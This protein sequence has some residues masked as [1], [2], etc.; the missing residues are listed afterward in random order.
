MN[1]SLKPLNTLIHTK[2]SKVNTVSHS[3]SHPWA[4]ERLTVCSQAWTAPLVLSPWVFRSQSTQPETTAVRPPSDG[5][6]T[7]LCP[8]TELQLVL[9]IW[10]HSFYLAKCFQFL[11][12]CA[13]LNHLLWVSCKDSGTKHLKYPRLRGFWTGPAGRRRPSPLPQT[14]ALW[15]SLSW[16]TRHP[17]P[18]SGKPLL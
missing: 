12:D 13:C 1:P 18:F 16:C 5:K 6:A 7:T 10:N 2:T 17:Q 3:L 9:G 4:A 11:Q 14:A 15:T 8:P